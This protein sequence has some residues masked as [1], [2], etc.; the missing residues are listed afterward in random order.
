M[1]RFVAAMIPKVSH[2][3]QTARFCSSISNK[4][5][6]RAIVK[7]E[8]ERVSISF[9]VH[10]DALK[11]TFHFNR[12]CEEKLSR[13]IPFIEDKVLKY[14]NLKLKKKNKE[15]KNNCTR[16]LDISPENVTSLEDLLFQKPKEIDSELSC[17]RAF[18]IEGNNYVFNFDQSYYYFDINPPEVVQALLPPDIRSGFLVYPAVKL[19]NAL[20]EDSIFTWYVSK[21]PTKTGNKKWIK[22]SE[23]FLLQTDQSMEGKFL[24]VRFLLSLKKLLKKLFNYFGVATVYLIGSK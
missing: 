21:C 3:H 17:L 22:I 10:Y 11:K 2:F 8:K 13:A 1:K 19:N 15:V 16:I 18:V 5:L 12:S 24:K 7:L 14:V 9:R 20:I 6:K 23:G 4:V